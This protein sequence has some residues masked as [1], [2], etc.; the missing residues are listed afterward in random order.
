MLRSIIICPDQTLSTQLEDELAAIGGTIVY[1][2]LTTYPSVPDL[3][4][5]LRA[6]APDLIF[7]SFEVEDQAEGVI[8]FL[9]KESED[10]QIIGIHRACDPAVLRTMMRLGVREFVGYPFD[11]KSLT[12]S[13]QHASVL[14]ARKPAAYVTTT[15]VFSFL[16]SKAGVGT[17]TLA[18]NVASALARDPSGKVLLSDFD[19]NSGMMRFLLK[20]QN[21]YSVLDAV[22][23]SVAM[24][25]NLWPQLVTT[26][27]NLDVLHAGPINPSL[28]IEPTQ[29]RNLIQ[30]MRRNYRAMCFDLSGNLERY[31]IEIMQESKRVLLVCTPEIPSLHLAREKMFYLKSLDLEGRISVVLNRVAKKPLFTKEQVA[32]IVG[33]PVIDTVPND[34]DGVNSATASGTFVDEKSDLG[35]HYSQ[36]ATKLIEAQ[37]PIAKGKRKFLQHF[38]V[39]T[40][41][42]LIHR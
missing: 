22:E 42:S 9:E 41:S 29:V 7:L 1:R 34:Y 38:A 16:P 40:G 39:P 8:Q 4:R 23:H 2:T 20:L 19:L 15:Q 21:S 32:E 25:E 33:A 3:V 27:G 37:A 24:D 11:R 12:E 26:I 28:R 17:S 30:F 18:L 10:A 6:H 36:V 31:S 5:T 13:L 14:L 35:K